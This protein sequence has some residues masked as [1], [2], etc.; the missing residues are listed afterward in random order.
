MTS[1]SGRRGSTRRRRLHP[2]LAFLRTQWMW[3]VALLSIVGLVL[4]VNPG[5]LWGVLQHVRMLPLLLMLP[6][7]V[8]IYVVRALGWRVALHQIGVKISTHRTVTVMIAGQSLVFLPAGDLA[9]VKMVRDTGSDGH[10]AGELTGTIA[11]QEL[12]YMT[13]MGF[14]VIPAIAQ[15]PDIGAIV[16]AITLAQVA[17]FFILLWEPGYHWAVR[18]VERIRMLRRFDKELRDIRPAFV[19]LLEPRAGIPILL[20]N[21][22]AVALAF[23]LFEL[24]LHAVG[25]DNVGYA[26][27]AFIYALGHILAALSLLPGGVGIYEGILTAFMAMQGVPPSQGAAAALLYRGFNDIFMALLG[28][29]GAWWLRRRWPPGQTAQR[30]YRDGS[31]RAGATARSAR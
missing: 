20:W 12:L 17:I 21:A 2:V 22:L 26:K 18:T 28:L 4:A 9:R 5:K 27:A 13:L 24:A 19:R 3:V 8:A 7:T 16:A 6:C 14:A 30:E 11:F 29:G 10:D 25:V 23:A 31:R 1:R 15:H